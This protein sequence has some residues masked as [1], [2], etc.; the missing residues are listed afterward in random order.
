MD[1]NNRLQRSADGSVSRP[2]SGVSIRMAKPTNPIYRVRS[3]NF[4]LFVVVVGAWMVLIIC[5]TIHHEIK[6]SENKYI[7]ALSLR[8]HYDRLLTINRSKKVIKCI[9]GIRTL[10]IFWVI[11]G[12]IVQQ[13][14]IGTSNMPHVLSKI[15]DGYM[16]AIY[17]AV[18]SVDSFFLMGGLLTAYLGTKHW[19]TAVEAGPL[20]VVKA[21]VLFVLNRYARLT[22]ILAFA[23]WSQIAFWPVIGNGALFELSTGYTN[24][25]CYSSWWVALVYAGAFIKQANY[26]CCAWTWYLIQGFSNILYNLYKH[27]YI[28]YLLCGPEKY[29]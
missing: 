19:S 18:V 6:K 23:I 27:L 21:Y 12:H 9:D 20:S 28:I 15:K 4:V 11:I 22:P 26:I 8:T 29:W 14:F 25:V 2:E 24:S 16:V 13:N 10:S 5:S 7:E 17:T 1:H 3:Y